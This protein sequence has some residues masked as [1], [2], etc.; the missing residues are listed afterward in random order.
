MNLMMSTNDE[1]DDWPPTGGN[2][3]EPARQARRSCNG[4]AATVRNSPFGAG[5]TTGAAGSGGRGLGAGGR[6]RPLGQ[7]VRFGQ[8]PRRQENLRE[9][10]GP[11]VVTSGVLTRAQHR[12]QQQRGGAAGAAGATSGAGAGAT[13]WRGGE[14]ARRPVRRLAVAAEVV[15]APGSTSRAGGRTGRVAVA[16]VARPAA[17]A[18]PSAG[19]R[20]PGQ[21]FR[22]R[23]AR[24][25]T[26]SMEALARSVPEAEE[27]PGDG[28]VMPRRVPDLSCGHGGAGLLGWRVRVWWPADAAYYAGVVHA[29]EPGSGHH[30]VR[31]DDG[32]EVSHNLGTEHMLWGGGEPVG[33]GERALWNEAEWRAN[34]S[35][36]QAES[37][38]AAGTPEARLRG[39]MA[40]VESASSEEL[41]SPPVPAGLEGLLS[42]P[43]EAQR[44]P[45]EA[46]ATV[47]DDGADGGGSQEEPARDVCGVEQG[48]V[49]DEAGQPVEEL[50]HV[51]VVMMEQR[52]AD[53][54]AVR[55]IEVDCRAE[56]GDAG[57]ETERPVQVSP[58]G[59][60]TCLMDSV[61]MPLPSP[62]RER[63]L[64]V[65]RLFRPVEGEWYSHDMTS[66]P[67]SRVV[68][69]DGEAAT[70]SWLFCPM[71]LDAVG[72]TAAFPALPRSS[73]WT[74]L[75]QELRQVLQRAGVTWEVVAGFIVD[76]G[77]A[78]FHFD[79]RR[80]EE[81][82]NMDVHVGQRVQEYAAGLVA[83]ARDAQ[84]QAG[85]VPGASNSRGYTRPRGS[86]LVGHRVRLCY[87]SGSRVG[88]VTEFFSA[89][90]RHSVQFDDDGQVMQVDLS[91]SRCA[92]EYLAADGVSVLSRRNGR[93]NGAPGGGVQRPCTRV[94]SPARQVGDRSGLGGNGGPPVEACEAPI[95]EDGNPDGE[96]EG[97]GRLP[98]AVVGGSLE[99]CEAPIVEEGAGGDFTFL[100]PTALE[101]LLRGSGGEV[102]MVA[103]DALGRDLSEGEL[104]AVDRGLLRPEQVVRQRG[105]AYLSDGEVVYHRIARG[106][107][108]TP[109]LHA[110]FAAGL[111]GEAGEILDPVPIIQVMEVE[112]DNGA[113]G[114]LGV[115]EAATA[116][117]AEVVRAEY[118]EA[119]G[120]AV[121]RPGYVRGVPQLSSGCVICQA[122]LN[123]GEA[124]SM[125]PCGHPTHQICGAR[126]LV[127]RNACP[128]CRARPIA[129][130]PGR[131]G[132]G[133][134]RRP[135]L[136]PARQSASPVRPGARQTP[137]PSPRPLA[138]G[139]GGS[140]AGG[141]TGRRGA[142]RSAEARDN[143]PPPGED[144]PSFRCPV[145]AGR[146]SPHPVRMARHLRHAHQPD[147]YAGMDLTAFGCA[148]CPTCS[149]AFA[150]G[151]ELTS[152][153][154]RC[155]AHDRGGG[156]D[157]GGE[158]GGGTTANRAQRRE[159]L[160][161]PIIPEASWEW[162]RG[163][164][165][166]EVF[167]CPF[168]TARHVPKRAKNAYAEA[169][170]WVLRSLSGD[171][172]DFWR[173]LGVASRLLLAPQPGARRKSIPAELVRERVRR[174][175]AGDWEA[176]FRAAAPS[177]P[178]WP[179]RTSEERVANDVFSL[180]K[181]GQLAKAI[182]RLDPGVL[183]PLQPETLEALAELHPA[184]DGL[185]AQVQA[186]PL[187]LE[188]AAVEAECRRMPVASGPGCSQLRFEHLGAI[189][190]AGDGV[191]AIKHACEQLVS[192]R[193]PSGIL[194]WLMGARL[195][196][197]LKP[198]GGV[199]PIACGETTHYL[200]KMTLSYIIFGFIYISKKTG[201][202]DIYARNK[203][204]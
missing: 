50:A 145:C 129:P 108:V 168:S 57:E 144:E 72:W 198:G 39:R 112:E 120:G 113:S 127:E 60:P 70:F 131:R 163:L 180:V 148:T 154:G 182:G 3:P 159:Q 32:E 176:L 24:R 26:R 178:V 152:H 58:P 114:G 76:E 15:A 158:A 147:D 25:R 71:I 193:V 10:A 30:V 191:H 75:V 109:S 100:S 78:P 86:E 123:V 35:G 55:P 173:L 140:P 126:W 46:G 122:G 161:D 68:G 63:S 96:L 194:P 136:L 6:T 16:A 93:G 34:C 77:V 11:G 92:V 192:N 20:R 185:P 95:M 118:V 196:A 91:N 59:S 184:G 14:P 111:V 67:P 200:M 175:L 90:G 27:E 142:R 62:G 85:R 49:E 167:A 84:R 110:V 98:S 181:E 116:L 74:R 1:N 40:N 65:G 19:V 7:L 52:G 124:F 139:V 104:D 9:P 135:P 125:W 203:D 41:G 89:R 183:A 43:V 117:P 42:T 151:A 69:A 143:D 172:E 5:R 101:A 132:S 195:V 162:L 87:Q 119:A 187:V 105:A 107:L 186:A 33:G 4:G 156:G 37:P 130:L 73:D 31:Y 102:H 179:A 61:G 80:Q 83:A 146:T 48:D 149:H 2:L 189:F 157:A 188:E 190:G 202:G 150:S 47:G 174:M 160:V 64:F 138:Q 177:A 121:D 155:R 204:R 137:A 29:W 199:R 66:M 81:L 13:S 164:P 12:Q 128:S 36:G 166:E 79:A 165:L 106:A 97:A 103:R 94:P 21:G 45:G 56:H 115:A 201:F 28:P 17:G 141:G 153:H 88:M 133:Q 8:P 22:D 169:M 171:N 23:D 38:P 18:G 134:R 197:L 53:G 170:R 82:I 54:E 44:S 99:A 51:E